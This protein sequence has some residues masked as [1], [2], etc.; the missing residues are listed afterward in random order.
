MCSVIHEVN[1]VITFFLE[2]Q[3]LSV[4]EEASIVSMCT[5]EAQNY[6]W[7]HMYVMLLSSDY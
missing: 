4:F 5:V 6:K 3:W 7:Q 2:V 1:E